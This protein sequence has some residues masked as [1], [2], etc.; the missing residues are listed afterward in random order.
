MRGWLGAKS[1]AA[2]DGRS[3]LPAKTVE[4]GMCAD[5]DS[6]AN[7]ESPCNSARL[8]GNHIASICE[9]GWESENQVELQMSSLRT[10]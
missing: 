8:R 7:S 3:H 9:F 2:A 6:V 1:R 10:R 5:L 4:L